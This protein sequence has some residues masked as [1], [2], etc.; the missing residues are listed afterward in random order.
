MPEP[1]Q[2]RRRKFVEL[3]KL[4]LAAIS[5]S[6]T[7]PDGYTYQTG[8]GSR[9]IARWPVALQFENDLPALG[10]FD[11]EITSEQNFPRE[12]AI[13]NTLP[14]QVRVFLKRGANPDEVDAAIGDIMRAV[15]TD[16]ETGQTD[17]SFGEWDGQRFINSL[18]IDTK[19]TANGFVSPAETFEIDGAAVT[20]AIEFYTAAFN[21]YE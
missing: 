7:L 1:L 2:T 9:P 3:L 21:A 16:P 13:V 19:P 4:R 12:K 11:Q 17:P 15:I 14:V 5:T 10:I 20:F 8:L 6:T 18:A